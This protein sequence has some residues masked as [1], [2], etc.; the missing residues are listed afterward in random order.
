MVRL[1]DRDGHWDGRR[2]DG[3]LIGPPM[4]MEFYRGFS[5]RDVA[6]IVLYLRTAPAVR[7]AVERSTY[8]SALVPYGPPVTGVPDPPAD[9]PVKRGA[10]LAGP[11]AHCLYCHTP[12][13]PGDRQTGRARARAASFFMGLGAWWS[14]ATS[15]PARNLALATGPTRRSSGVT[16]SISR[17]GRL[18]G[19]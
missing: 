4:P 11:V 7:N 18:Q 3:S 13:L 1:G 19:E 5:D 16:R 15:L 10:Y 17:D 12:P 2:P 6:A 8:P 9:D 14:A